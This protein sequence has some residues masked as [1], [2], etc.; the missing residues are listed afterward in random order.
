MCDKYSYKLKTITKFFIAVLLIVVCIGTYFYFTNSK[1]GLDLNVSNINKNRYNKAIKHNRKDK[2]IIQVCQSEL[3]PKN[4]DPITHVNKQEEITFHIFDRLIRWDNKG[5]HTNDLAEKFQ[6]IANNTMQIKLKKG[7]TFHNG[8]PFDAKSVKFSINRILD[9]KTRSPIKLLLRSIKSVEI[10]DPYTVNIHTNST[11]CLV[12][13]KL[14]L[15]Q[16]IPPKYF[17]EVGVEKFA[18]KPVG[19]SAYMFDRYDQDRS[20]VLKKNKNYWGKQKPHFETI[21]FKFI[22]TDS[23]S[24]DEQLQALF[25]G[26]IDLITELPGIH[27]LKVQKHPGL[28]LV[29]S[30]DQAVV[31]K[32]LFNSLKTPFS[33]IKLRKAVNLALNRDLLIKV[34]AKGNGRKIATNS[35]EL[36]F[37]HNPN[38]KPYPY[39][40]KEAKKLMKEAGVGSLDIKVVVTEESELIARA[41][42]K[43]LKRININVDLDI[44]TKEELAYKLAYFK[45]D[46][47]VKW[48]YDLAIYYGIDPLMHVGFMY[49]ET[50]YFKGSWST[51]NNKEVDKLINKLKQS[52]DKHEQ[53]KYCYKLEEMAYNNYWYTPVF[54]VI[55]TYGAASDLNFEPSATSYLDLKGAYFD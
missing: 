1:V 44:T 47:K 24:R 6:W 45:I 54:Q 35:V 49:E 43:D 2:T 25:D 46:P 28:K 11:D 18:K 53:L 7:I 52:L 38:L 37:G 32:M 39:D 29:K 9:L 31:Y 10:V 50:L 8:E 34:L 55:G 5:K 42:A 19:T 22:K 12:R 3:P 51:T 33:N 26:K 27:T 16:M 23:L 13:Q 36:Q 4:L 21:V 17:K 30:P 40:L 20:I 15:V 48:N 14:S 41:I